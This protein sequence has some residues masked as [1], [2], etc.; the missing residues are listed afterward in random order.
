MHFSGVTAGEYRA[1]VR[2]GGGTGLEG[3]RDL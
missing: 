1:G 2:P 3:A